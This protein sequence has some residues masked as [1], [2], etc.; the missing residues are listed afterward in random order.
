MFTLKYFKVAVYFLGS[1]IFPSL[2]FLLNAALC[3][4]MSLETITSAHIALIHVQCCFEAFSVS[5][6]LLESN[7][8]FPLFA[9]GRLLIEFSSQMTMERVQKENPNVT[10]GGRYTPPDCRSRW[11]VLCSSKI[12]IFQ[13]KMS[14]FDGK[15]RICAE[16]RGQSSKDPF[17]HL[18]E[19]TM[20]C[21]EMQ[22]NFSTFVLVFFA[23]LEYFS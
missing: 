6:T 20:L 22:G 16:E 23:L 19:V 17:T 11:K 1:Y 8:F 15:P 13:Q 3:K 18:N 10:E 12:H 9:V 7:S 2:C 4:K 14:F 21:F 5:F